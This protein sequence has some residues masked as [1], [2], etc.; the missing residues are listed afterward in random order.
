MAAD[1]TAERFYRVV[2]TGELGGWLASF[3]GDATVETGNGTTTITGHMDDPNEL[4]ALTKR[5]CDLGL[6]IEIVTLI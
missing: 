6:E 2:V 4:H 1:M 5:L 3:V